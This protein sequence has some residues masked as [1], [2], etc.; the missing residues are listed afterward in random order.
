MMYLRCDP[1]NNITIN[2]YVIITCLLKFMIDY[3][4]LY[5]YYKSKNIIP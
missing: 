5:N 3:P 2:T 1:E 4:T